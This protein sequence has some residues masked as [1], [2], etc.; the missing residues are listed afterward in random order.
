MRAKGGVKGRRRHK[1]TLEAAKGY[2]GSRSKQYRRAHEA[3]LHA[4]SYAFTGR[5]DRKA[6][7]RRLWIQRINAALKIYS[8]KYSDF[9]KTLKDK[10]ITLDRKVMAD[11]SYSYPQAFESLVKLV[12]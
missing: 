11:L 2:F 5:K 10:N 3:V 7:F 6:N 12:K 1:R 9:I 4:G 8:I